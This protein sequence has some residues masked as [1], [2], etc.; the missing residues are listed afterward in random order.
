M[1]QNPEPIVQVIGI[2]TFRGIPEDL[3]PEEGYAAV[4]AAGQDQGSDCA[5]LIECAGRTCYDSYGRGRPSAEY[6]EHIKEVGHG[7]VI[8]HAVINFYIANVSRGLTHELVR[9]RAGVAISQRSTRYVDESSSAWIHHPL[10]LKAL[11]ATQGTP[12]GDFTEQRIQQ[13]IAA[14]RMAYEASEALISAYLHHEQPELGATDR[15]KQARG[16][17]RGYLGNALSTALVWSAN[18]RALRHVVEQRASSFA[19]GEIRVIE[20]MC[21]AAAK[22]EVPEYFNDYDEVPCADG[23]GF[24]LVP[25]KVR[26]V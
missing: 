7:S 12:S 25:R 15:R 16:A 14:G 20:D 4:A 11:E 23:I 26:K 24:G 18:I 5:R 10:L 9:H 3:L 6:H 19:D 8:E 21:Y 17:A 1:L 22:E 2:S 13:A